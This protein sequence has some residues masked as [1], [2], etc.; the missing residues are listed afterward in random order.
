MSYQGKDR[1]FILR[2]LN[3]GTGDR[4]IHSMGGRALQTGSVSIIK[5]KSLGGNRGNISARNWFGGASHKEL[6]KVAGQIQEIID[7]VINDEFK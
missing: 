6:E 7:R 5:T 3:Q 2:F 1:G 4:A